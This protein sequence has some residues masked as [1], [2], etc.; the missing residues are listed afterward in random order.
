MVKV[1]VV[2]PAYNEEKYI[3]EAI[4]SV[5]K[6]SFN[7]FE[8]VVVNDCSLDGTG[9]MVG[10]IGEKDGRVRLVDLDKN[11]GRAGAVNKGIEAAR[12]EYVAFLDADD[13]M[14][15]DRLLKEVE[16]L[17]SHEDIDL[18]YCNGEVINED[19]SRRYIE[20]IEFD[21]KEPLEILREA[22][23]KEE[24][25][26][27]KPARILSQ[28]VSN[29]CILGG[30]VM[31]KRKVF[32]KVELDEN[33]KNSEDYDLWFSI[34]G[35]GFHVGKIPIIGFYY[36]INPNQKSTNKEKMKIAADIISKKVIQGVYFK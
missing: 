30:T 27:M 19:G 16:F 4:D 13:M 7:D 32:E 9:E 17:D 36:R 14:G 12:G 21:E 8:I 2:I 10:K 34:I 3:G 20:A 26:G 35:A 28:N 6:Q 1:S 15:E 29:S 25:L 24:T 11:V 22:S 18:V 31:V 23:R 33:L 5:L